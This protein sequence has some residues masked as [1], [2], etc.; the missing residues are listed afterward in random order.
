[1][2]NKTPTSQS[3]IRKGAQGN[4]NYFGVP[5][6]CFFD[7]SGNYRCERYADLTC[8]KNGEIFYPQSKAVPA[9]LAGKD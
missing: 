3:T 6:V 2:T 8:H 5:F 4:A 1:M 9:A 7:T